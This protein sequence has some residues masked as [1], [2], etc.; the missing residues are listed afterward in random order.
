MSQRIQKINELIKQ[1]ISKILLKEIDFTDTLVT[2]NSADTSPDLKNC[3]IKVS[4]IPT[5]KSDFALEV[6]QKKIY[7]IQQEFN[8]KLHLKYSPK[9]SFKIDEIETKAQRI[10]ELLSKSKG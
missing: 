1:E 3:K 6:I 2:V 10:E 4:I 5:D 9:L 8:K 7:H